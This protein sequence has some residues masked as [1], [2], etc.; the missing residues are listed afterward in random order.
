MLLPYKTPASLD[1]LPYPLCGIRL[2]ASESA[3]RRMFGPIWPFDFRPNLAILTLTRIAA[4]QLPLM[5]RNG[6]RVSH[7]L[8]EF[9]SIKLRKLS[10]LWR[11]GVPFRSFILCGGTSPDG[12]RAGS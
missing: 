5:R 7:V 12:F 11:V 1:Y 4:T 10:G 6:M 8:H 3:S 9:F 2:K